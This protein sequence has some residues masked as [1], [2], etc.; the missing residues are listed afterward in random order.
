MS[1]EDSVE[2]NA[3]VASE[4]PDADGLVFWVIPLAHP[5][6]CLPHTQV[7][8]LAVPQKY[9]AAIGPVLIAMEMPFG[10]P[11]CKSSRAALGAKP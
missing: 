1:A 6:H 10:P 3:K 5:V 11:D 7:G 4:M 8:P 9:M 2:H